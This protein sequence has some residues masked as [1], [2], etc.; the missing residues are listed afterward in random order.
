MVT[1]QKKEQDLIKSFI[2]LS[3]AEIEA[4]IEDIAKEKI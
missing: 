3:H 2:L 4:F 1:I